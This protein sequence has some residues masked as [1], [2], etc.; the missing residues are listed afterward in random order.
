MEFCM[1]FAF[2][3]QDN[4]NGK[5]KLNPGFDGPSGSSSR[6]SFHF[7]GFEQDASTPELLYLYKL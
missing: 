4:N 3:R 2:I 6:P 7:G 1:D 5:Y